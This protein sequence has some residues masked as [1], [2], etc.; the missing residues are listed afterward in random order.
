MP[1]IH[2]SPWCLLGK[3]LQILIH[4]T[5]LTLLTLTT[6][7]RAKDIYRAFK[8]FTADD[9]MAYSRSSFYC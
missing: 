6:A 7:A 2:G 9:K 3:N 8:N 1:S 5:F 4:A